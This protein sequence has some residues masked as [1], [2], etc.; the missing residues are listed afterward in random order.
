MQHQARL[1]PRLLP[2]VRAQRI[3]LRNRVSLPPRAALVPVKDPCPTIPDLLRVLPV[4]Y[5]AAEPAVSHRGRAP[6]ASIARFSAGPVSD[7]LRAL[8][9]DVWE[10]VR[11]EVLRWKSTSLIQRKSSAC[12]WKAL[13][14]RH[15]SHLRQK[16]NYAAAQNTLHAIHAMNSIAHILF[17]IVWSI[18]DPIPARLCGTSPSGA[19]IFDLKRQQSDTTYIT[20]LHTWSQ[21][22]HTD[23]K[24]RHLIDEKQSFEKKY[25]DLIRSAFLKYIYANL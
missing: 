21:R 3:S 13:R 12:C 5:H 23:Y 17:A 20:T 18:C 11:Q 2:Q 4:C 8:E 22:N 16:G 1:L 24:I 6:G 15:R 19:G 10:E 7:I 14:G 9:F 25:C